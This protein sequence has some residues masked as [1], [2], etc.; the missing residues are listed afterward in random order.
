M[1][2]SPVE[3]PMFPLG[4]VLLPTTAVSLHIFEPRYRVL[5]RR[6]MDGDRRL[7]VVLIERG[8]EVGGGDVRFDVA[9]RGRIVE[10][11]ELDD[12]RWLMAVVGE[13]RVR[14]HR[15]LPDDPYPRAEVVAC[16]DPPAGAGA[17]VRRDRLERV[18]HSVLALRSELG[19]GDGG[20]GAAVALSADPDVATWQ[21]AALAPLGPL[22]AQRVLETDGTGRRL[23]LV[24]TL[25]EEEAAV[26]AQRVAGG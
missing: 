21:A 25:L 10:A 16:P 3:L 12:G 1:T 14:V 9:T 17:S 19:E 5:A 18:L 22:D 24:L 8:S 7:G 13:D 6:C 4:S 11:V 2:G 15:W 23:D 26:L 20:G